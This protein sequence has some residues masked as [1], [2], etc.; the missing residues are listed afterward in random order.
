MSGSSSVV[1]LLLSGVVSRLRPLLGCLG[2]GRVLS[3]PPPPSSQTLSPLFAVTLETRVALLSRCWL[4]AGSLLARCCLAAVS[5]LSRMRSCT[6]LYRGTV[7]GGAGPS[8]A[9]R[10]L[11]GYSSLGLS[12]LTSGSA[13]RVWIALAAWLRFAPSLAPPGLFCQ[14]T[15]RSPRRSRPSFGFRPGWFSPL[16]ALP[17]PGRLDLSPPARWKAR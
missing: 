3:S 13:R 15:S 11:R 7:S 12:G 10:L 6:T 16:H 1:V 8:W 9:S 2:S 14:V 4:A 5:L 17:H